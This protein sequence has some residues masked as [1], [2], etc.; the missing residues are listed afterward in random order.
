[1]LS[2]ESSPL[3]KEVFVVPLQ[4]ADVKEITGRM[5]IMIRLMAALFARE[6]SNIDAIV[7]LENM[8]LSREQIA[9]ALGITTQNVR[10]QLYMASKKVKKTE[11]QTVAAEP[12]RD[13]SSVAAEEAKP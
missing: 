4:D 2:S 1:V 5:D 11:G 7:K 3:A 13:A 8:K 10:Q 6:F 9:E 12:S